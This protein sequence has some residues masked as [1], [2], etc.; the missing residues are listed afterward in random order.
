MNHA[1][2]T[3]SSTKFEKR[4]PQKRN[5]AVRF[6]K[7]VLLGIGV[8][9]VSV[10]AFLL[11]SETSLVYPGANGAGNWD[12]EF[13]FEEVWVDSTDDAK[14]HG[15]FLPHKA[16]KRYVL[17]CHGNAENVPQVAERYARA[18][19]MA[20]EASVLVFDYRG[21]GKSE[22]TPN[23]TAVIDDAQAMLGWLKEKANVEKAQLA[24]SY[25]GSSLG[26]GVAVGLAEREQPQYLVLDR[27]FDAITTAAATTYPWIPVKFLMRNRFDSAKRIKEIDVPLFQSHFT[28]DTL[29][30]NESARILFDASPTTTKHFYEMPKGGHY[31]PLPADY[32]RELQSY[33]AQVP[34]AVKPNERTKNEAPPTGSNEAPKPNGQ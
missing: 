19:G 5:H 28:N 4:H 7:N 24:I 12:P 32:W 16:P 23:E 3:D 10:V 30:R 27:T 2:E 6:L 22:G 11:F 34:P 25:Y 8:L 26:G 15:W 14:I 33:F 13:D 1:N 18:V 21:F 31:D 29:C 9:Y 20:M 17:L